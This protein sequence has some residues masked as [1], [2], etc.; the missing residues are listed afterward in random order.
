MGYTAKQALSLMKGVDGNA[1]SVM[2]RAL[3]LI[4]Q[5]IKKNG[6]K[7]NFTKFDDAFH[8]QAMSGDYAHLLQTCGE[9]MQEIELKCDLLNLTA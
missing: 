7:V 9:W 4:H 8:K 5:Y 3:D 6:I 1:F 2:G